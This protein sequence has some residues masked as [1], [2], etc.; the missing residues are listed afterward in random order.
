MGGVD[1]LGKYT[2]YGSRPE[3]PVKNKEAMM[4]FMKFVE[5]AI[6]R[7]KDKIDYW[8]VWNEP[9]HRNYWGAV[10]DGN[11]YGKLLVEVASLIKKLD[12]ECKVIGGSMA[13]IDPEF[14]DVYVDGRTG[15]YVGIQY[16]T[17]G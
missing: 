16:G 7:Y 5:I 2:I 12:P 11:E 14:T 17:D 6:E 10:P 15:D 8:E 9:N 4:A 13:G 1:A 3:P